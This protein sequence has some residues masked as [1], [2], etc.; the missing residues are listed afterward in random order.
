VPLEECVAFLTKLSALCVLM[1]ALAAGD[2][3]AASC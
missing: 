3:A 2:H 1:T